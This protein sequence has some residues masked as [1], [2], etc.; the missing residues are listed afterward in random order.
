MV[1]FNDL[2]QHQVVHMNE[3]KNKFGKFL[4][5]L[6]GLCLLLFGFSIIADSVQFYLLITGILIILFGTILRRKPQNRDI[7]SDENSTKINRGKNQRIERF[8]PNQKENRQSR[9]SRRS[10]Y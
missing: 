8:E 3:V 2:E 6:G 9:R 10:K 5:I 7:D 4:I 1:L